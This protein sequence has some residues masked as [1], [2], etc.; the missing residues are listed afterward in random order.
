MLSTTI[1]MLG[2]AMTCTAVSPGAL[3]AT[4]RGGMTNSPG[5]K[6]R[7]RVFEFRN[8]DALFLDGLRNRVIPYLESAEIR[9]RARGAGVD[10]FAVRHR[11]GVSDQ[12]AD[13]D[14]RLVHGRGHRD[15][16]IQSGRMKPRVPEDQEKGK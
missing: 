4:G 2:V 7:D 5:K 1:L 15:R 13:P 14:A 10:P 6:R 16:N 9:A 12:V 3:Y 8:D 11:D